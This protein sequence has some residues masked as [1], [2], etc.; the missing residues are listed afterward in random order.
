MLPLPRAA[1]PRGA[2]RWVAIAAIGGILITAGCSTKASDDDSTTAAGGT[3]ATGPGVSGDTIRLGVLT[4]QTGVFA[5]V[6]KSISQGR[7]LYWDQKNSQGGVCNR[8][9]EFVVKDH[10]YNPQQAVA[11]Y[12]QVKDNVLALDELL[13]SP[14]IAALGP[15]IQTDQMLT[16]AAS[17]SSSLLS[18]PY[19]VVTGTTYD[20]EMINGLQALIDEKK[21]AAGDTIGHIFLEGDYGQNA[22]AGSQAAAKEFGLHL[23]EHKITPTDTDLTAP[24]TALRNAGAKVILLTTTPAQAASAV[25][26]AAAS[27]FDATFLGSSPVFSPQ[28]LAGPAKPALEKNLLIASSLAPFSADSA[29]VQQVRQEFTSKYPGQPQTAFVMYGYAQ[30]QIMAQI[31]DSACR[32][33]ALTRSGLLNGL[34]SLSTV[35]T[36]GLIAPLDYSKPGGIPARQVYLLQPDA[37]TAGGLKV[38]RPLF[39]STLGDSYQP[40][41]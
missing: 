35:D 26:V 41:G 8:R 22:L 10:G 14:V 32:G 3:M 7:Q 30:G 29:G 6:G 40:T 31:L 39:S 11:G 13:G 1:R 9:V 15:T 2:P 16:F 5:G 36:Q 20:I 19:V 25:S 21:V 38:V 37:S 28:L 27:G 23:V 12:A 4:D 17:F 34:R 24:V 33:G 18:N